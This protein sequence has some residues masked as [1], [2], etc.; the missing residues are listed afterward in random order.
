MRHII[1]LLKIHNVRLLQKAF[2]RAFNILQWDPDNWFEIYNGCLNNSLSDSSPTNKPLKFSILP[3]ALICKSF[4]LAPIRARDLI[5]GACSPETYWP[6]IA[7]KTRQLGPIW[8]SI[9]NKSP[10]KYSRMMLF[11]QWSPQSFPTMMSKYQ[12]TN[13]II[14][15]HRDFFLCGLTSAKN[16]TG[17]GDCPQDSQFLEIGQNFK[18]KHN[19]YMQTNP[20]PYHLHTMNTS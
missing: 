14:Y 9:K 2:D 19:S 11:P 20:K 16:L 12:S 15:A 4:Y 8:N 7:L 17:W 3:Q 13:Y 6:Q 1:S 5:E 18:Q 10:V